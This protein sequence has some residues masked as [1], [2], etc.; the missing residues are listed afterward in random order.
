M[1]TLLILFNS[2]LCWLFYF[3]ISFI[4][5]YSLFIIFLWRWCDVIFL[6]L[7]ALTKNIS[8]KNWQWVFCLAIHPGYVNIFG[9]NFEFLCL[10]AQFLC[11][12]FS[13]NFFFLLLLC[14]HLHTYEENFCMR[15]EKFFRVFLSMQEIAFYFA[16]KLFHFDRMFWLNL[17]QL[18]LFLSQRFWGGYIN[19][20]SDLVTSLIF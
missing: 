16:L 3:I 11:F 10:W 9:W 6:L 12:M 5:F 7:H 13:E 2:F 18:W 8:V 1:L 17:F 15:L 4:N 14:L 19:S 20:V